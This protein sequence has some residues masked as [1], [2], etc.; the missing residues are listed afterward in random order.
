[1]VSA[2]IGEINENDGKCLLS[3]PAAERGLKGKIAFL[4]VIGAVP[5]PAS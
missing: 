3:A 5:I 4:P 2:E 1:M